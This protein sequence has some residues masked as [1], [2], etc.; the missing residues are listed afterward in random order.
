MEV[1]RV[2]LGRKIAFTLG[3]KHVNEGRLTMIVTCL[4]KGRLKLMD[5]MA[6]KRPHIGEAQF[7]PEHGGH[8][9]PL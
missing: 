9:K 1:N 8:D 5:V 7:F 2:T 4:G 6:V 3:S